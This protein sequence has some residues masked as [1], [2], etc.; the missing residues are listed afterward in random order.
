MKEEK[1]TLD[2]YWYHPR[3]WRHSIAWLLLFLLSVSSELVINPLYQNPNDIIVSHVVSLCLMITSLYSSLYLYGRFYKQQKRI[4][5]FLCHIPIF[6]TGVI[7]SQTIAFYL[8]IPYPIKIWEEMI[9]WSVTMLVMYLVKFGYNGLKTRWELKKLK[10]QFNQTAFKLDK[11]QV[12]PQFLITALKQIHR[13]NLQN[14]AFANEAILE[15]SDHLRQRIDNSRPKEISTKINTPLLLPITTTPKEKNKVFSSRIKRHLLA[16]LVLILILAASFWNRHTG[17]SLDFALT[18][19]KKM[20]RIL[21]YV[22][23]IYPSIHYYKKWALN[24]KYLKFIFAQIVLLF[25]FVEFVLGLRYFVLGSNAPSGSFMT[26]LLGSCLV[27]F[28][29]YLVQIS[30]N[31]FRD[32]RTVQTL[33]IQQTE[34]ELKLLK[35]QINPHFLFNVL[36]NIYG[37]NLEDSSKANEYLQ[38]LINLL[39]YQS[40]SQKKTFIDLEEEIQIVKN[41]IELEKA[42]VYNCSVNVTERGDF[43]NFKIIPLLLLP[44]IENAFKYGTGV[45]KGDIHITFEQSNNQ[46][47]FTCSNTIQP[48]KKQKSSTGIGLDN[49][50]KRLA[51]KYPKKHEFSINPDQ[52]IFTAKINIA[53]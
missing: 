53:L 22:F 16:W 44:I 13:G 1:L 21:L 19:P 27:L 35:A 18:F 10:S 26:L 49:V 29:A 43:S 50:K 25:C 30:Y 33:G 20:P 5:F 40:G 14:T 9:N 46:F 6:L 48:N 36:N 38:G 28:G 8:D 52:K 3:F 7:I 45:N 47:H 12:D 23:L 2:N 41:Y 37:T 17:S 15:L 4:L 34:A 32:S 39:Q 24:K 51:I 42:R 31:F 11:T